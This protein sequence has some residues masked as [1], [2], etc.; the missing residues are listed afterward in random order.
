MPDIQALRTVLNTLPSF[1]FP[2]NDLASLVEPQGGAISGLDQLFTDLQALR[3]LDL[4]DAAPE[5]LANPRTTW[6]GTAGR[7]PEFSLCRMYRNGECD[8]ISEVEAAIARIEA[9]NE[10][11]RIFISTNY[12]A[13]RRAAAEARRRLETGEGG[14]LVGVPFVV[15]DLFRTIGFPTTA[16][17]PVTPPDDRQDAA[18]V[19]ALRDAGAVLLGKTNLHEWAYGATGNNR[20]YGAVPH[21]ADRSRLAGGS[22]SGS[23][24][25]VA[26]GL[27]AF[28]LGTDTGGSVRVPAALCGVVGMKPTFGLIP[29][30][31]VVPYSWTLDHVGLITGNVS[32]SAA[33]L[34]ILADSDP[35]DPCPVGASPMLDGASP[36]RNMASGL[37]V[38]VCQAWAKEAAEPEA[39]IGMEEAARA[40]SES[41]A[42]LQEVCLEGFEQTRT[43][44][45][46]LQLAEA[47]SHLGPR[48]ECHPD[49]FGDD[50]RAGLLTGQ[51][52]LAEHYVRARRMIQFYTRRLDQILTEVDLLLTPATPIEA[53]LAGSE[54]AEAAGRRGPIGDV[55]TR[56][57]TLFNIT[58][59]PA[60]VVP[61]GVWPS[62]LP[63]G[64]QLVGRR[65]EDGI[66]LRA[67]SVIEA[68]YSTTRAR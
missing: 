46:V 64:I 60:V 51:L 54:W 22:S 44:S 56:F 39:I 3:Q 24:A 36:S 14:P 17:A 19:A 26:L 10:R 23:A 8:P 30:R 27:G 68:A 61:V 48:L 1:T 58:G 34:A 50:V 43:V 18:C 21:P 55:L 7:P 62:G 52:L 12:D 63:R 42:V 41:G 57:T 31:G 6:R 59:H 28:A 2:A 11:T 25:A 15:K 67:A 20:T 45:L 33:I 38:G 32:D 29:C 13:T 37:K 35:R 16:G 53:P 9:E 5:R 66:V 4:A 47:V 40:L 49:D 65:C